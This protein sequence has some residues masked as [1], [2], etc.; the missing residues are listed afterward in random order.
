[1]REHHL[2]VLLNAGEASTLH[3]HQEVAHL[4]LQHHNNIKLTKLMGRCLLLLARLAAAD[5]TC[6]TLADAMSYG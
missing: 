4:E 3:A 6:A 5:R 1:M 2:H